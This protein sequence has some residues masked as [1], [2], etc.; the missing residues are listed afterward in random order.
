MFCQK[1]GKENEN[2]ASFCN[3]CGTELVV[4]AP[5]TL[6]PA[7]NT[8]QGDTEAPDTSGTPSPS[9][10]PALSPISICA[11]LLTFSFFMP[12][13]SIEGVSASGYQFSELARLL[14]FPR[15]QIVWAVPALGA[16]AL[17]GGLYRKA[18]QWLAILAGTVPICVFIYLVVKAGH[19]KGDLFSM[20]SFGSWLMLVMGVALIFLGIAELAK[21]SGS[22][23]IGHSTIYYLWWATMSKTSIA[24]LA[25]VMNGVISIFYLLLAKYYPG[26]WTSGGP[27]T[28]YLYHSS[29][30]QGWQIVLYI[31]I[32][33][34]SI[35][36]ASVG[37]AALIEPNGYGAVQ[38]MDESIID[39]R[40]L[41]IL[42]F[43]ASMFS[44]FCIINLQSDSYY[45]GLG[46]YSLLL[47]FMTSAL[48][49]ICSLLIALKLHKQSAISSS[50]Q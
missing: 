19:Y 17:V 9:R 14:D 7:S 46:A 12:W 34:A 20:L 43:S 4:S 27:W 11:A 2:V 32:L 15:G 10:V 31:V 18:H 37:I 45:N 28:W 13:V 48:M 6:P 24:S 33:I 35:F 5:T 50:T 30:N 22:S 21:T 38:P 49:T 44:I 47:G 26:S 40:K 25:S 41:G 42:L 3:S 39:K 23:Q 16:V 1:C 36:S 29:S 8:R